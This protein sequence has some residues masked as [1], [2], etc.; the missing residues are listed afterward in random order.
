MTQNQYASSR[1]RD[2]NFGYIDPQR[3]GGTSDEQNEYARYKHHGFLPRL[4]LT[5]ALDCSGNRYD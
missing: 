3:F 4:T 2:I 5:I 1:Y